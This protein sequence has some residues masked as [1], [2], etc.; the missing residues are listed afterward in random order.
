MS[1][2]GLSKEQVTLSELVSGELF[3]VASVVGNRRYTTSAMALDDCRVLS[4]E[5]KPFLN[6]LHGNPR[7]G[8]QFAQG[9]ARVYFD[10]YLDV[11]G[12]PRPDCGVSPRSA[13]AIG[14]A[15]KRRIARQIGT[16]SATP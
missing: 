10:R 12:H 13:L 15:A 7:A 16:P 5:S 9:V 3:G 6:L 4:I 8:M 11:A 1:Q 2:S 14:D